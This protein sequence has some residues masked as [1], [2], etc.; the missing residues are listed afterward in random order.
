MEF[1]EVYNLIRASGLEKDSLMN[2]TSPKKGG[3]HE[4]KVTSFKQKSIKNG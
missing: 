3:S 4:R 2:K 1:I